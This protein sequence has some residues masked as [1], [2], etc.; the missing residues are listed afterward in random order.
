MT[1]LRSI[2]SMLLAACLSLAAQ[3]L[4]AQS[5]L[6]T[7]GEH[8]AFTRLVLQSAQSIDW[9][10]DQPAR[11]SGADT[12]F[13]LRISPPA[14]RIDLSRA[15]QRIPRTRLADLTRTSDG[16]IL[17]LNCDCPIRAWTERPGLVVLDI[18]NPDLPAEPGL[19]DTDSAARS[20]NPPLSNGE[21]ARIA[22]RSLALEWPADPR[23]HAYPLHAA[24]QGPDPSPIVGSERQA[25]M[26][27]VTALVAG[28]LSQ[29]ILDP[30]DPVPTSPEMLR[31]GDDDPREALPPNLRVMS[32]LDR[33]S[34]ESARLADDGY[35]ACTDA[36]ALDFAISPAPG[37]F[38][39]AL[40][41]HMSGWIGEF[42]Q[43]DMDTTQALIILYLQHGF[44]AEARALIENALQ[45]VHGRD[46]LLGFADTLEGRH[47]NSRLRLAEQHNCGGAAAMLASLAGAPPRDIQAQ[48]DEIA[49]AFAQSPAVMRN[50]LGG[51]LIRILT[52][53]NSIDAARVVADTLRRTPHAPTQDL[54]IAESLLDRARGDAGHADAR[55]AQA[56]SD[57]AEALLIRLQFAFE[58]AASVPQSVLL[59]AEAIASAQRSTPLGT[60]LMATA[61]RL[62]ASG[63]EAVAALDGL[64]R[65]A[66]WQGNESQARVLLNELSDMAW[67]GM[68][69]H[70][71]DAE[72][73]EAVLNRSD[74]RARHHS[75]ATRA[76]LA[77]RLF[78]FGLAE[79]T[80]S[81]LEP[82]RT[83][84]ERHLL[85]GAHLRLD[86]PD[87]ALAAL[88]NDQS[89]PAEALR[90]SAT[91]ALG[92]RRESSRILAGLGEYEAAARN[93]V[94][95]QD[96]AMVEHAAGE[97][98]SNLTLEAL[99]RAL[100]GIAGS[101]LA[102]AARNDHPALP[103]TPAGDISLAGEPAHTALPPNPLAISTAGRGPVQETHTR[104]DHTT[105][106]RLLPLS[107]VGTNRDADPTLPSLESQ[108][109]QTSDTG[110]APHELHAGTTG[111]GL[112]GAQPPAPNAMQRG[113]A[114]LAESERLR[115][116]LEPL[117]G[118]PNT[119]R[120]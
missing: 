98:G 103:A 40:A 107:V 51:H 80:L 26:E 33:T 10:L 46:L 21:M 99:A 24:R 23:N 18:G 36:T 105:A 114:L 8:A 104:S 72:F 88:R 17:N 58:T 38:N 6:V 87:R 28:A 25:I 73:I 54:Q 60:D 20:A 45:P 1:L 102:T 57:D 116:I 11:M 109:A 71:T 108:P 9:E 67:Y 31:L 30:T 52:D 78:N 29:G 47:S 35:N 76:A 89:E 12:S 14:T 93:A 68:A 90:A 91:Q 112:G 96:W 48:G 61:I 56:G 110:S 44:G 42:D 3:P 34:P 59:N 7:T 49:R 120:N 19:R 53:A 50:G 70:A 118:D 117:I 95:A 15:F 115:A 39:R 16:L 13:T 119:T 27:Q 97:N 5:I 92:N 101:E 22:G 69:Q 55:L 64:D 111:E 100:G 43:P 41:E 37:D 2:I 32:V 74:W 4:A 77:E 65:L 82:P 94:L 75:E 63:G 86:R 106:E 83:A 84:Q 81:M 66:R 85:A 79:E 62:H 113:A